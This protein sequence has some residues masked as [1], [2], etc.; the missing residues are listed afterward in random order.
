MTSTGEVFG[1]DDTQV[2]DVCH[3]FQGLVVQVVLERSRGADLFP[4]HVHRFALGWV[5]R[6]VPVITPIMKA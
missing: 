6:H 3:T 1:Y 2:R 4:R 5:E